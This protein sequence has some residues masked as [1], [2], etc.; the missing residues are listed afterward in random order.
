MI[1]DFEDVSDAEKQFFKLW[2]DFVEPP[3]FLRDIKQLC[4]RFVESH[5][6]Q[7]TSLEEQY[8][9]LVENLW[10]EHQ[11]SR[12]DMVEIMQ[13]Y[14]G[15]VLNARKEKEAVSAAASTVHAASAD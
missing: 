8:I 5:F 11:I 7:I 10:E 9:C 2:N 14:N 4:K 3:I 12:K 6:P 1:D 13:H 15:T